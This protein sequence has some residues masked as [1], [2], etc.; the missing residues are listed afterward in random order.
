MTT[1][2]DLEALRKRHQVEMQAAEAEFYNVPVEWIVQSEKYIE[3]WEGSFKQPTYSAAEAA[4]HSE[5]FFMLAAEMHASHPDMMDW[6]VGRMHA[7]CTAGEEAWL[8]YSQL[9]IFGSEQ[10]LAEA[11]PELRR[12]VAVHQAQRLGMDE[13]SAE[14]FVYEVEQNM[15]EELAQEPTH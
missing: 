14:Q 12:S 5:R 8:K 4:S 7:R 15:M 9:G 13:F 2:D 6:M 1:R 3:F 11:M 10:E